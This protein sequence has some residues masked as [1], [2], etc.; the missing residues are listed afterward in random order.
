MEYIDT[1]KS[2]LENLYYLSG[3]L[4]LISIVIGLIQLSFAKKTLN[5]NSKR[6]AANLAVKQI[7]LYMTQIIPLQNKLYHLEKEKGINKVKVDVGEFNYMGL[8][9]I[10]GLE[11]Y[12]KAFTNRMELS[13]EILSVLNIMEAFSVYFIKEVADEEIAYSSVGT[14]FIHSVEGLYFDIASCIDEKNESFQN[15]IKL[16]DVWNKKKTLNSLEKDKNKLTE[17]IRKI[18]LIKIKP[19]GTK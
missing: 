2:I 12:S 7:D 10:M 6:E 1:S 5:I 19:L 17:Q 9:S 18:K 14:T 4:I 15:L 16:Y 11:E 8:I 13:S 3:I